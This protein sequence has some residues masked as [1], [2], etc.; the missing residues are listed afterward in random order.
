LA[1]FPQAAKTSSKT[2]DPAIRTLLRTI[3]GSNGT[4]WN[5]FGEVALDHRS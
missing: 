2:T 5:Q 1:C 3:I 4:A